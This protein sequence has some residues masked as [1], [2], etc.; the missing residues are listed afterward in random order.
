MELLHLALYIDKLKRND[1]LD[2]VEI[3]LITNMQTYKSPNLVQ[4]LFLKTLYCIIKT[5]NFFYLYI[6]VFLWPL[7]WQGMVYTFIKADNTVAVL[8][9]PSNCQNHYNL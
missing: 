9:I 4:P 7:T 6:L 1:I 2:T 5:H 3:G 8:V